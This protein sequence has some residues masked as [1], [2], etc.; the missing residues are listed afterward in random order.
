MKYKASVIFRDIVGI[1][2]DRQRLAERRQTFTLEKALSLQ[3]INQKAH[4][5][6]EIGDL[7][8][9]RVLRKHAKQLLRE[10][11]SSAAEIMAEVQGAISKAIR[12]VTGKM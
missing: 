11:Q 8:A 1:N 2:Q 7:H 9:M 5:Y 6:G 3:V 4:D 10:E 12:E